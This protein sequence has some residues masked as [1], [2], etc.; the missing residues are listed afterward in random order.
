MGHDD[1]VEEQLRSCL[2]KH[3]VL[4]QCVPAVPDLQA[5]WFLLT[6]CP[7]DSP[8]CIGG[9][10][11]ASHNHAIC[12]IATLDR[13]FRIQNATKALPVA[14]WGSWADVLE[15]VRKRHPGVVA[16]IIIARD[17]GH[18]SPF[19]HSC[20]GFLAGS[21]RFRGATWEAL[22]QGARPNRPNPEEEIV[23]TVPNQGWQRPASCWR[24][25]V[26]MNCGANSR[27]QNEFML[28]QAGPMAG[29]PFSSFPTTKETRFDSQAFRILLL[30]RLRLPLPLAACRCPMWPSL[31][32][33]PRQL[34][35]WGGVGLHWSWP[36]QGFAARQ[37]EG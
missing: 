13:R 26:S 18:S 28:S 36:P 3:D 17:Q 5:A 20:P 11:A 16:E 24:R 33:V 8:S 4:L 34:E 9:E 2:E 22:A 37:G 12:D 27:N 35:C 7:E 10:F 14:Q 25:T 31:G 23:D 15:M 32:C 30:R 21:G 6:F 29:E 1:F 19:N